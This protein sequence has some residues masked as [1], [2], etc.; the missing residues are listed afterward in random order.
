V[1]RVFWTPRRRE[2]LARFRYGLKQCLRYT[3]VGLYYQS[4]LFDFRVAVAINDLMREWAL[5]R[6][7]PVTPPSPCPGHPETLTPGAALSR[8]ERELWAD[9]LGSQRPANGRRQR[10]WLTRPRRRW[11]LAR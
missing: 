7:T 4:P 1:T 9:A 10:Q 8:D 11:P 3:A 6:P 2:W 5:E